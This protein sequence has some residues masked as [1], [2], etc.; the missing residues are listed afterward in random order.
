MPTLDNKSTKK[1]VKKLN[2]DQNPTKALHDELLGHTETLEM[3]SEAL[4]KPMTVDL[5]EKPQSADGVDSFVTGM[6]DM[7]RGEKGEKGEQGE[8]GKAGEQGPAGKDGRGLTGPQG[9]QGFTG[10]P[11]ERGDRG[12]TGLKGDQG[13]EGIPGRDGKDGKDGKDAPTPDAK[14]LAELLKK[15]PEKERLE[16]KDLRNS[17]EI[18]GAM[19]KLKKLNFDDLRWHGGGLSTVSHDTTLTGDGTASS[20]L[21]ALGSINTLQYKVFYTVGFSNADYICD[22]VA[23]DVQI[24]AAVTAAYAAGGG[25]VF[26][27][28]GTYD[29]TTAIN[30]G[31]GFPGAITIMGVGWDTELKVHANANCYIFDLGAAGIPLFTNGLTI[32]DM[33]LNGNGANQTTAGGGIYARGAVWCKFDHLF[34]QTPWEAGIRFY[35]DGT[36]S[37]GHHNSMNDCLFRDGKDSNGGHGWAI[38]FEQS[39]ENRCVGCT[40]QDNGKPLSDGKDTQVYDTNAGINAFIGCAWVGGGSGSTFVKSDSSPG[41]LMFDACSFDGGINTDQLYFG[42]DQ[43]SV[44]N[45]TFLNV[46]NGASS[47]QVAAI[48]FK[49]AGAI[50]N[51]IVGNQFDASTAFATGVWEENSANKNTVEANSFTGTWLS[52]APVVLIGV[53]SISRDNQSSN[54]TSFGG[55]VTTIINNENNIGL[56]ITQNDTTNNPR[57]VS[58]TNTGTAATLF[59]DPNGNASTSSSSGGAVL[60]ENTGNLGS[61]MVIYSNAGASTSGARLLS[62][63]ADNVLYDQAVM[64]ISNDGTGVALSI[65][66]TGGSGGAISASSSGTSETGLFNYTGTDS[67]TGALEAISSNPNFSAMEVSG[68]E[69]GHGTIK[70]THTGTGTDANAAAI[71]IDLEGSGTAAQGMFITSTTGGTTGPLIQFKNNMLALGGANAQVGLLYLSAGGNFGIGSTTASTPIEKLTIG[72]NGTGKPI[73]AMAET[74]AP[75]LTSGFGKFYVKSSDS[76]P[77]FLDDSGNEYGLLE[78]RKALRD[79]FRNSG[80]GITTETFPITASASATVVVTQSVY[81]GLV[82]FLKGDIIT[83]I[84]I[85]VSTAVTGAST[86]CFVAVLDSAGNRLAVSNDLTTSADAV[87]VKTLALSSP[88]TILADGAYYLALLIVNTGTPPTLA[89]GAS[90]SANIMSGIGSGVRRAAVQTGQTTIPTSATFANTALAYWM[91]TS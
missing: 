48:H 14:R 19:G 89:R 11:G 16:L 24:Q 73:L 40:F 49:G 15:L 62:L 47:G 5:P 33:L 46:G 87:G 39:D 50:N 66:S 81:Y 4:N 78:S 82:G 29:I 52:S 9:V 3:I 8:Q 7:I 37:Y 72:T 74:T 21:S 55:I 13:P 27:K 12:P 38:K 18:M 35:Q 28:V 10:T 56:S 53:N 45:C 2:F 32:K 90:F 75:S 22:G 26:I 31:G 43:C 59:I 65:N 70:I 20:P 68:Q 71:S 67:S 57:A 44:V 30:V 63:R 41:R 60:L 36:G 51:K 79:V 6:L 42:G 1:L 86:S 54:N 61:G 17:G 85:A 83:N 80:Q 64:A 84:H 77:Y 88:Y 69:L 25:A 76:N 34:I 91:A 23:D 58:L